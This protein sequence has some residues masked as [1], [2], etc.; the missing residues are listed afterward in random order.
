[1]LKKLMLI[2]N[3]FSGR[4]LSKTKLGIVVSLFCEKGY[5]VTVYTTH[6]YSA[7]FLVKE[8]SGNF[9]LVVCVGG[10]GT[11]SSVVSGLMQTPAPPPFGF[12]PSGTANDMAMTLALSRDPKT[13]VMSVIN[14]HPVPLDVGCFNDTYFTYIA[15]FGAFTGVSYSTPQSAKRALGHLAYVL[16]GLASM[17]TIKPRHTVIEYDGGVIEGD[18]IFGGVTNS[19]SIAGF[20][21]LDRK[22]VDLCDG[23]FEVILVKNPVNAVELGNII[24]SILYQSYD[25]EN[26]SLLHTKTIKFHFDEDVEW[27]K[28]GE[29]GG[30]HRD[31]EITNCRH[32]LQIII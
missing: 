8:Y 7:E 24:S 12:I 15:A 21:K 22:D 1:M 10:D 3:P 25:G 17:S 30:V 19:T 4:G 29:N 20:V 23:Q 11:V 2:V 32:A 27:T 13:A 28:D 31:L 26:V 18:Y 14:G 9:D 5:E 6:Q 16:G